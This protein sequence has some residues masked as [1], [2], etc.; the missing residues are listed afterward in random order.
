MTSRRPVFIVGCGRSGTTLLQNIVSSHS[1]IEILRRDQPWWKYF[2][3]APRYRH[4]G[5]DPA[6]L[7]RLLDDVFESHTLQNLSVPID[8]KRV[9]AELSASPSVTFAEVYQMPAG[10]CWC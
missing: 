2:Y 10:G 8:R 1:D 4:L 5:R 6:V 7:Q 3:K 9:E